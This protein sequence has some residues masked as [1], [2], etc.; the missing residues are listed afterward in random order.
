L[1]Y[2]IAFGVHDAFIIYIQAATATLKQIPVEMQPIPAVPLSMKRPE[3]EDIIPISSKEVIDLT[4]LLWL[5]LY[6]ST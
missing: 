2:S 1:R 5:N 4:H 6:L 3:D